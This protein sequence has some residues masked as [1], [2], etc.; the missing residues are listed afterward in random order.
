M[1]KSAYELVERALKE[2]PDTRSDDKKLMMAVWFY[3]DPFYDEHF[4]KFFQYSAVMPE[5][6]TRIRRKFQELDQYR[7]EESID[8]LRYKRFKNTK[9]VAPAIRTK[10]DILNLFDD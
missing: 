5:T 8:E 4:R 6:I 9:E 2:F 3:Q 10:Q 7:A 1:S